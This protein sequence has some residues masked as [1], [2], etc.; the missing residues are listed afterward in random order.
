VTVTSINALNAAA[1]KLPN[2]GCILKML[3]DTDTVI[4]IVTE[5]QMHYGHTVR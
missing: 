1:A 2:F 5:C 3:Q 4:Q